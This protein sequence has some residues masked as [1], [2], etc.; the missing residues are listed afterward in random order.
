LWKARP[1]LRRALRM[2]FNLSKPILYLITRG[3][4]SQQTTRDTPEFAAILSQIA[5]AVAARVD[6]CQIREKELTTQV[7]VELVTA[8]SR[9]TRGTNTRLL[10]NDRAD[11]AAG[12][13]ADGVHLTTRSLDAATIRQAFGD[14]LLIG[15]STHALREARAARDQGADFIVFGPVFET[16]SK[17]GFGPPAGRQKLAEV[18]RDLREF[19]VLALGGISLQNAPDCLMAGAA[20]I[21]GISIFDRPEGLN[22][23]CE[24]IRNLTG[25]PDHRRL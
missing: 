11:V 5:A 19:P 21:A 20:G 4:T 18:V 17:I 6:V 15:V 14:R 7:L 22:D 13:G 2:K 9:L 8:A 25:S 16:E 10:V 1:G 24:Q 3:A 23:V 12:A